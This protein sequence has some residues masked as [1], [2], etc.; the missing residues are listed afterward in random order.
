MIHV[1][2]PVGTRTM[3]RIV[4]VDAQHGKVG[5]D[6]SGGVSIDVVDV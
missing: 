3:V 6:C 2:F 5:S 4:V 1:R